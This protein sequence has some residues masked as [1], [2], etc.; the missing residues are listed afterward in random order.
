MKKHW[1]EKKK[2]KLNNILNESKE[3]IINV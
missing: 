2:N 3:E 1:E